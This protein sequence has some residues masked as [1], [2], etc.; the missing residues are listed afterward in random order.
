MINPKS[1]LELT[2]SP[3]DGISDIAFNPQAEYICV[4][5]WDGKVCTFS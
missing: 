1:D 4:T 5:S 3:T 2:P